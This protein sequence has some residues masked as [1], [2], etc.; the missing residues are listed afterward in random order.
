MWLTPEIKHERG[1]W[2]V[3][4]RA[5]FVLCVYS[6][7]HTQ[8]TFRVLASVTVIPV[9]PGQHP[10]HGSCRT[11]SWGSVEGQVHFSCASP[12]VAE[13][14]QSL[15]HKTLH[16]RIHRGVLR[17]RQLP[18]SVWICE[19]MCSHVLIYHMFYVLFLSH[20][21]WNVIINQLLFRPVCLSESEKT[22][23]YMLFNSHIPPLL[24]T[25]Y[26][27]KP[28]SNSKIICRHWWR[29]SSTRDLNNLKRQNCGKKHI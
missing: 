27:G 15:F 13:L 4:H 24:W 10:I 19:F 26:P 28:I 2:G 16:D 18:P 17:A 23:I 9:F 25:Q 12:V 8:E 20:L 29:C 7:T 3:H 11:V 22:V 5:L 1:F 14:F 21:Q 6:Y